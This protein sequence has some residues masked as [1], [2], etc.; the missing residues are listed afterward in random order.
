MLKVQKNMS[1]NIALKLSDVL[2]KFKFCDI[3]LEGT[4]Y[5]LNVENSLSTNK[6][7]I[8]NIAQQMR[9][10]AEIFDTINRLHSDDS[11]NFILYTLSI[12][13]FYKV[14][15]YIIKCR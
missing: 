11:T 10:I 3:V 12:D 9:L 15:K 7:S 13:Y 8:L 14:I 4:L 1:Y 6:N 2:T 5:N